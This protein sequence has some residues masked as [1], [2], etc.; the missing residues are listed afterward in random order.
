MQ[1][2]CSNFAC[3]KNPTQD[4][5]NDYTINTKCSYSEWRSKDFLFSIFQEIQWRI[6]SGE[7]PHSKTL[8]EW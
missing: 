2:F 7:M 8:Y 4:I 3:L 5:H 6:C 1:S